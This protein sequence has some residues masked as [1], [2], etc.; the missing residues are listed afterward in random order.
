MVVD[1]TIFHFLS[2]SV[3]SESVNEMEEGTL[4]QPQKTPVDTGRQGWRDN[5]IREAI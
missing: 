2:E 3:L 5:T 4:H 1:D